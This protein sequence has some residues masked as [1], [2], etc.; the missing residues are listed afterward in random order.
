M[1]DTIRKDVRAGQPDQAART[2]HA[3]KGRVGM[4][5]MSDLHGIV[6]ALERALLGRAP[7]DELL[8]SLEQA[9]S[10]MRD[11]LILKL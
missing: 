6:S 4:L 10:S 5:G 1:P 7:A 2:V 3:F 8:S 9:I 11:Q